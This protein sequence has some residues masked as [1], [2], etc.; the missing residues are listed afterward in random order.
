MAA[1]T[2]HDG[3]A[4]LEMRGEGGKGKRAQYLAQIEAREGTEAARRVREAVEK[5]WK[6]ASDGAMQT[7]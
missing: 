5:A 7:R 4:L 1:V 6:E 2:L 3:R